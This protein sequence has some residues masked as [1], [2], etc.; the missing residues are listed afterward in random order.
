MRFSTLSAV[1]FFLGLGLAHYEP[2]FGTRFWNAT[3]AK[4]TATSSNFVA[5]TSSLS[6]KESATIQIQIGDLSGFGVIDL[7]NVATTPDVAQPNSHL[8]STSSNQPYL[9]KPNYSQPTF[10]RPN[11][12]AT[13]PSAGASAPI[14][15]ATVGGTGQPSVGLTSLASQI[16]TGSGSPTS[17]EL[18]KF[19]AIVSAFILQIA[20][21][22][23][24]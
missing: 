4:P 21:L 17:A 6:A 10:Y 8:N 23:L 3:A 13:S 9:T 16:F 20:I 11:I 19:P 14:F 22:S 2:S 18:V 7:I 15:N 1:A 5:I 24:V 12:T